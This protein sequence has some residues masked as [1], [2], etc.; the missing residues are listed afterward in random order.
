[1]PMKPLKNGATIVVATACGFA[2]LL[3][4]VASR[5]E[6]ASQEEI[7]RNSVQGHVAWNQ[8]GNTTWGAANIAKLCQGAQNS[9]ARI[10]CFSSEVQ[11]GAVW[12]DAI[13]TCK[14]REQ[15][16]GANSSGSNAEA[17]AKDAETSNTD[18]ADQ[19]DVFTESYICKG[20]KTFQVRFDN[21]WTYSIAVLSL[22]DDPE[23]PLIQAPSGS[24]VI[25]SNGDYTL[26]TKADIAVLMRND[27]VW[28]CKA[29]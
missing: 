5:A 29:K 1:M 10:N 21:S 15:Q 26:H 27:K 12:D 18:V 20:G 22:K 24:G 9:Q 25:Y 4:L 7:C 11:R 2:A 13:A 16:A 3:L 23:I 14:A 8:K 28:D 19:A 6:A 17:A